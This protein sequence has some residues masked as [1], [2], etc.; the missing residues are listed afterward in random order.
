MPGIPSA[1][2]WWGQTNAVLHVFGTVAKCMFS[3]CIIRPGKFFRTN[4]LH[5]IL[6]V[7]KQGNNGL[8][9]MTVSSM[10]Y[11][12]LHTM[13][14]LKMWQKIHFHTS[15][16]IF[17]YFEIFE[18]LKYIA[19]VKKDQRLQTS[20][21]NHGIT[22]EEMQTNANRRNCLLIDFYHYQADKHAIHNAR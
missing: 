4:I 22:Y 9:D 2:W 16:C 18:T 1:A 20:I 5:M 21:Y 7:S 12:C 3:T 17:R 13:S 11:W 10:V 6:L 15:V 14:F 19:M 8:D